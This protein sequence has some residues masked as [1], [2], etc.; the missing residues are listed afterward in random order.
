VV[1]CLV[2]LRIPHYNTT[3]PPE[4]DLANSAGK[5]A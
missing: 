2:I 4:S 3:S 5:T 1:F